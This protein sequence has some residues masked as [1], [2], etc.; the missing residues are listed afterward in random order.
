MW[1]EALVNFYCHEL[2]FEAVKD[3]ELS[4]SLI[5]ELTRYSNLSQKMDFL[6]NYR[7]LPKSHRKE[8]IKLITEIFDIRNRLVHFKEPYFESEE[9]EGVH[10]IIED[11]KVI[12]K[13]SRVFSPIELRLQQKEASDWKQQVLDSGDWLTVCS[14][15]EIPLELYEKYY[16]NDKLDELEARY[17]S[18][19]TLKILYSSREEQTKANESGIIDKL[20]EK[21]KH[22][23]IIYSN[24]EF[25]A[26]DL[27]FTM[28]NY[29]ESRPDKFKESYP[30]DKEYSLKAEVP[31]A[32]LD[33]YKEWK[34]EQEHE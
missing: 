16:S 14:T 25:P 15:R 29:E 23:I 24:I 19:L 9:F 18:D 6:L 20:K 5:W 31:Q 32:F 34:K 4:A 11:D 13:K 1:V 8:N 21:Y 12:L 27:L 33:K 7:K 10:F 2:I 26:E 22:S 28:L 3:D 30:G 17:G